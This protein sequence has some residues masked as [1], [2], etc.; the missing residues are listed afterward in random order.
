MP[1]KT[2]DKINHLDTRDG[3]SVAELGISLTTEERKG[4][5]NMQALAAGVLKL[6]TW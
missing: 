1:S 4:K 3:F 5:E 6:S 2:E